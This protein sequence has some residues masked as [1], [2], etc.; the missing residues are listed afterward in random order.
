ARLDRWRAV[1]LTAAE[2]ERLCRVVPGT[3][4]GNQMRRYWH[5]IAATSQIVEPI[6]M[7]IKLLGEEFVLYRDRSGGLG[8]L[9]PHCAHRLAGLVYGVPDQCGLRC[10]YHGWLYDAS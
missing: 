8:L 3:A 7:P 5:P 1:M 4:G 6:T 2:N 10:S 9:E